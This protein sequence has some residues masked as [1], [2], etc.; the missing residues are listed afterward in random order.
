MSRVR[1][2]DQELPTTQ[3]QYK[4]KMQL[5]HEYWLTTSHELRNTHYTMLVRVI[6][7]IY[8]RDKRDPYIYIR[9]SVWSHK[10]GYTS[11]FHI[12][13][14]CAHQLESQPNE[15]DETR[16]RRLSRRQ[17]RDRTVCFKTVE[18]RGDRATWRA[19]QVHLSTPSVTQ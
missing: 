4:A 10:G 12:L 8:T 15:A 16:P 3:S 7:S 18:K 2:L 1:T 14:D 9:M 19:E 13:C 17:E 11:T 5:Q 6:Q